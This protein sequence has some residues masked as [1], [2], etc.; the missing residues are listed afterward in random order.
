VFFCRRLKNGMYAN[1]M[2]HKEIYYINIHTNARWSMLGRRRRRYPSLDAFTDLAAPTEAERPAISTLR[3]TRRK[4][5]AYDEVAPS[6]V[7]VQHE[8]PHEIHPCLHYFHSPV[9]SSCSG[10]QVPTVDSYTNITFLST[11]EFSL[12]SISSR[13]LHLGVC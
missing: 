8:G 11:Q 6:C 10:E 3:P 1:F 13:Q 2:H 9:G 12:L 4:T 5:K 7:L